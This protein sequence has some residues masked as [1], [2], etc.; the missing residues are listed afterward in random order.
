MELSNKEREELEFLRGFKSGIEKVMNFID[1]PVINDG[2]TKNIKVE[3]IE[4]K[5][6][7]DFEKFFKKMMEGE[8][9]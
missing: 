7:E 6:K 1:E 5:S 2:I 8:D 4:V 3:N 9:F